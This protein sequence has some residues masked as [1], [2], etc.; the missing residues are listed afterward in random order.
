MTSLSL[1]SPSLPITKRAG[2]TSKKALWETGH[3]LVRAR[4]RSSGGTRSGSA[5]RMHSAQDHGDGLKRRRA[6]THKVGRHFQKDVAW[7][8]EDHSGVSFL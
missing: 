6:C 2:T 3:E 7:L 1:L 5:G 8:V 4:F